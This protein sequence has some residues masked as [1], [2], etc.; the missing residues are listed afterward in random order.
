MLLEYILNNGDEC[1][2]LDEAGDFTAMFDISTI[3]NTTHEVIRFVF[4]KQVRSSVCLED[5]NI[6]ED[7]FLNGCWHKRCNWNVCL[8]IRQGRI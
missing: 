7:K 8:G 3:Y 5:E 4:S 1:R 2:S 6:D